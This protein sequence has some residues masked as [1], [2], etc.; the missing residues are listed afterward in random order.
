MSNFFVLIII[1]LLF[2]A[3]IALI[4]ELYKKYDTI[5]NG[6]RCIGTIVD[7]VPSRQYIRFGS[8][9]H[10]VVKVSKTKY[11]SAD[12]F[13]FF[14]FLKKNIGKEIIV[15]RKPKYDNKYFNE[16]YVYKFSWVCGELLL[17]FVIL[18]LVYYLKLI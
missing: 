2:I 8:F 12:T 17:T 14:Y 10:Y 7:V 3:I 4:F 16:K 5:F 18:A 6:K 15:Y 9:Y 1:F 13:F 11:L